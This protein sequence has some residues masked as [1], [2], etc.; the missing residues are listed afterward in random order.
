MSDLKDALARMIW[1]Q[2]ACFQE[3]DLWELYG[4]EYGDALTAAIQSDIVG[5][6]DILHNGTNDEFSELLNNYDGIK[7][8]E[9]DDALREIM[10]IGKRRLESAPDKESFKADLKIG[11]GVLFEQFWNEK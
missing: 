4:R 6:W 1:L 10:R 5:T 2:K 9:E 3:P 11:F 8:F 7:E